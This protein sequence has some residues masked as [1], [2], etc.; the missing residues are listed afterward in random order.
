MPDEDAS[1]SEPPSLGAFVHRI[2]ECLS[3]L[4]MLHDRL[5][6]HLGVSPAAVTWG[7]VGDAGRVY[8]SL[9]AAAIAAGMD[10]PPPA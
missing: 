2:G 8:E 9:T 5:E 3:L 6:D 7:H 1:V 4:D 10:S